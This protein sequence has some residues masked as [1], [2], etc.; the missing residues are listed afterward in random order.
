VPESTTSDGRRV[1]DA[2]LPG[3]RPWWRFGRLSPLLAA[4]LLGVGLLPPSVAAAPRDTPEAAF[5]C[6]ADAGTSIRVLHAGSLTNL[7]TLTMLPAFNE[8]C[9]ASGTDL[10]AP[11]VALADEIKDGSV[12]GDLFMSA[13]AQVNQELLGARNGNWARWF[14]VFARNEMVITYSPQSPFFADLEKARL[15]QVPWYQVLTEPGFVLGRTDPNTDPGG[16]YAVLVAKLAE[17]YYGIPGLKQHLLGSDT[18][19]AQLLALPTF[20][21]TQ[22]G[23]MPDASFSYLSNALNQNLHYLVLPRQ[24][25]LGDPSQAARY[26]S[27]S[28][29]NTKGFTYRG[30]PIAFSATVL[31]GSQQTQTAIDFL[32]LLVSEQ[33]QAFVASRDFLSSPILV[34]G[35][36]RQLPAELRPYATG[37][38]GSAG[39]SSDGGSSPARTPATAWLDAFACIG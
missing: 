2:N 5:T 21:T 38:Y 8:L 4:G 7:V 33:G 20:A 35:D 3:R 10:A 11:S 6:Q 1:D 26:G 18:N 28:F 30:A 34:G 24:I 29:T 32:R 25:N 15:G 39:R 23:A 17:Q 14:L 16:Y 22:T 19:P 9:G 36:A 37:C 31:K 27:V 12:T 13:G